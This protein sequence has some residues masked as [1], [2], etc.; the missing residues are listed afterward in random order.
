MRCSEAEVGHRLFE[1]VDVDRR[2]RWEQLL[3]GEPREVAV[4]E[5]LAVGDVAFEPGREA[6]VLEAATVQAQLLT[7]QV[8]EVLCG[9]RGPTWV[10]ALPHLGRLRPRRL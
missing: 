6:H 10:V 2:Q 7:G 3:V 9:D 5:T 4:D 1:R 8:R